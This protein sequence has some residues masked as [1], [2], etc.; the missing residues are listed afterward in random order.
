[1]VGASRLESVISLETFACLEFVAFGSRRISH[2]EHSRSSFCFLWF[3]FI[4]VQVRIFLFLPATLMRTVSG[5][6]RLMKARFPTMTR[7]CR[8][9]EKAHS[10]LGRR[11]CA[12]RERHY[13]HNNFDISVEA[14][15]ELR[16][17]Y[18]VKHGT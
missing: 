18:I 13:F 3:Y 15:F 1:V 16:L 10:L 6:Y 14:S 12:Y 17:L 4:C 7:R 8:S 5:R 9:T 11:E 2:V